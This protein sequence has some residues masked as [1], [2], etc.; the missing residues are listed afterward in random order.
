MVCDVDTMNDDMLDPEDLD[1]LG[2]AEI[3]VIELIDKKKTEQ[4]LI[5]RE[6]INKE[7]IN[8]K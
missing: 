3:D 4:S 8:V 6:K 1:F 2:E 7:K 5:N